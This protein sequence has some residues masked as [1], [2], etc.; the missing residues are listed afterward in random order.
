MLRTSLFFLAIA[1]AAV[2]ATDLGGSTLDPWLGFGRMAQDA[3]TP[4]FA[5]L[6][7]ILDAFLNTVVFALCWTAL[8]V[9]GGACLAFAFNLTPV[10]LFCAFA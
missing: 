9:A 7:S 4:D 5:S 2:F 8:A 6:F 3:L 1:L 10:R